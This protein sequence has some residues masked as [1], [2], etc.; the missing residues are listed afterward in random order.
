MGAEKEGKDM[1][2]K[3]MEGDDLREKVERRNGSSGR[4]IKVKKREGKRAKR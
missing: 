4:R 1:I 3:Q 2:W